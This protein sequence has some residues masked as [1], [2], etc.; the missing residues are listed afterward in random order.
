MTRR[1]KI[2]ILLGSLALGGTAYLQSA[3]AEGGT[4]AGVLTCHVASGWGFVFGSSRSL[5]CTFSARPGAEEHYHGTVKKF[6]VD[7]GYLNSAVIVWTVL[8]PGQVDSG[9][10]AGTYVGATGSAEV[11]G[12]VGANVLVGGS[13]KSVSL[14]PLSFEGGTGLNVA[15]GIA[16]IDLIATP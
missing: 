2:S 7:I 8:A 16:A 4:K 1:L 6:G 3:Q 11:V 9:A 15:G 14:Q 12:G 5:N 10:L 13:S